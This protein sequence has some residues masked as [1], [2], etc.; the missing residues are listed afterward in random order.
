MM[1]I[2]AAWLMFFLVSLFFLDDG[3]RHRRRVYWLRC[4]RSLH[5]AESNAIADQ[6]SDLMSNDLHDR[7][8]GQNG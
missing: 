6:I 1:K 5:N 8:G 2:L 3:A 4:L 7:A